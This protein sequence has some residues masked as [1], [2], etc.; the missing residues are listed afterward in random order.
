MNSPKNDTNIDKNKIQSLSRKESHIVLASSS[1]TN[2]SNLDQRFF[3]EPINFNKTNF[4][5]ERTVLSKKVKYPIWI[6]SMTGGVDQAALINK[7]LALVANKFGL[8]MGLGSIRPLL[9]NKS[10]LNEFKVRS[11]LGEELPLFGNIGIAQ[12]EELINSGDVKILDSLLHELDCDGIFV[13]L[14]LLQE[15]FQPEGD[16]LERPILETLQ[17][18]LD[19]IQYPVFVKEVGHGFGPETLKKLIELPIAGIEFGAF[20]GTNFSLLEEKRQK[21][22]RF[23]HPLIYVGHTIDQMIDSLI[24]I[25]NEDKI[26]LRL[27]ELTLIA[28]GGVQNFLDGHYYLSRLNN[29]NVLYAH[30]KNFISHA[31]SFDELVKYT[32]NEIK[33]LIMASQV[34]TLNTKNAKQ[35]SV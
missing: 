5:F 6:S 29:Q 34:L 1:Q 26:K 19:V 20:G 10:R 2:A 15:W 23:E 24:E 30:A 18:F 22:P 13:H 3:Y 35:L 32:E 28:S 27:K 8:G 4:N 9:G 31:H 16:H 11:Y 33:G 7:N 25:S 12:V 17:R 21:N 14:N